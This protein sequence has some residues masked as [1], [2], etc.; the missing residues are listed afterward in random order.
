[1]NHAAT[2]SAPLAYRLPLDAVPS[3]L[4]KPTHPLV[5]RVLENRRLTDADSPNDV[6][7]LVLDI[8][9]SDYSYVEGQSVGILPPGEDA[10]GKPHKLR[11]YSIAS[12][13]MGDDGQ[14]RTLS[15]CVKRAIYTNPETGQTFPGVCSNYLCDLTEGEQLRATGPV[16]KGFLMPEVPNANMVMIATGTGIAPFRGFLF[17]RYHRHPEET[18]EAWLFFGVQT[19]KDNLYA[20]EFAAYEAL[21]TF[22]AFRAFS[23]EQKTADGQRL[24]VQHRLT[25]VAEQLIPLLQQPNTYVFM[26]GLKGMEPGIDEGLTAAASR[27][28]LSWPDLLAQLKQEKRWR[29]EV[30]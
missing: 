17:D 28:G 15:I 19:Q 18:G 11:L 2:T 29:V 5:C 20:Q 16:G 22:K 8:S 25:E 30:Y 10:Q 7:H 21:N 3:N 9:N 27:V 23:R 26:C 12:P 1:V 14:G 6:R 13:A 24:Y 4:Y